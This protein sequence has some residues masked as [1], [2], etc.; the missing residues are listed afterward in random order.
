M[1]ENGIQDVYTLEGGYQG[2]LAD[3]NPV[4]RGM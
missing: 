4:D 3:G 2:W 1:I